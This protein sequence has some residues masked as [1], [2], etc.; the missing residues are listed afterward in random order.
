MNML[1]SRVHEAVC[2]VGP[3]RTG[4]TMGLLDGWVSHSVLNDPGDMLIVQMSQ[5]K[6]REYSKTRID[7]AIRNSPGLHAMMSARGNDDNTHDKLFKNG[8][9]LKIGWPSASQL[10]SSD[11]RYVALTDYDRFPDDIDGEGSGYQLALKRTQT[12]LSRGMCMVESSPGRDIQDP[13]WIPAS[14]HEAPPV[15]GILGIY[16]RSDRR[17]WNW[18]C[19]DCSTYFEAKPGL[20][21]FAT[22]PPEHELLEIVRKNDLHALASHHAVV[23]CPHCGSIIEQ[24]WKPHLNRLETARWVAEG[25]S[26]TTDGDVIGEYPRSNIA[27]YWLGG[28]AAAY[29]KWDSMLLRYLQGLREYVLSG[30]EMTLKATVNTDQGMPYLPRHL[31]EARDNR[32]EHKPEAIPRFMVPDWA[33]FIVCAVDVQGGQKGRFVVS[34]HAIGMHNEQAII[35]R[36]EI[37][38]SPR[39]ENVQIDPAGYVEDWNA[40]TTRVIDSTYRIDDKRELRVLGTVVD[41]GGEEGT[42]P[43]A[44]AWYRGLRRMGLTD[45]V[46]LVKGGDISDQVKRGNPRDPRTNKPLRD[47]ALWIVN[48][49]YFKDQ[50][51]GMRR[52]RDPGPSYMHLPDWLPDSVLAELDA[53]IRQKNG[54]WKKI[55]ARN[56]LLDCWVYVLAFMWARGVF[57]EGFWDNPPAWAKPLDSNSHV[58]TPE[59]RRDAKKNMAATATVQRRTSRSQSTIANNE[60]SKRL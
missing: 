59:E 28:V 44:Y 26:V 17:R 29:Q 38:T 53:E 33:R 13:H 49:D 31:A 45:R 46:M 55:R 9:W 40:I 56:E 16:N 57:K 20:G 21:L 43:N 35:D 23:V 36:Y 42:T 1:A 50:V 32:S 60:W 37:T 3:S 18:K 19:P 58:M 7:R 27:G 24:K 10:S 52:R 25:Q 12:F 5:E 34:A 47:V 51:A 6:A 41:S 48:T 11:Y 4:K 15:N 2:F 39:G 54:K 30:A 8:M 14:S 22:L